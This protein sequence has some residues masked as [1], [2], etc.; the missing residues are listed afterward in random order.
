MKID[1]LKIIT[2]IMQLHD[3]KYVAKSIKILKRT[4]SSLTDVEKAE[5][6]ITRKVYSVMS[7]DDDY[8]K[9]NEPSDFVDTVLDDDYHTCNKQ[10]DFVDT[11]LDDDYPTLVYVKQK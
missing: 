5:M 3:G 9:C 11:V 10:N 8:H 6:Y 4:W 1:L 2:A 7:I